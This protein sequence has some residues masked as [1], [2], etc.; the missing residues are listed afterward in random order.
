M[1]SS[2]DIANT[3]AEAR[4]LAVEKVMET[5]GCSKKFAEDYVR[6]LSKDEI[7]DLIGWRKP[8]GAYSAW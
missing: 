4:E 3:A 2:E 6:H 8:G 5:Q 7:A 1:P